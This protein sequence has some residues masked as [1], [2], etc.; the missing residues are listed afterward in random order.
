MNQPI[1]LMTVKEVACFFKVS[2]YSVKRWLKTG[3]LKGFRL[4]NQQWRVECIECEKIIGSKK[5]S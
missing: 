1:K 2:V 4:P 5:E 3:K